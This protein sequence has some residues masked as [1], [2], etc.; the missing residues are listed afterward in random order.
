MNE[1]I[2]AVEKSALAA[3]ITDEVNAQLPQ[4]KDQA[5]RQMAQTAK[6]IK[7]GLAPTTGDGRGQ[8]IASIP[9]IVYIRWQQEYPGCWRDKGFVEEFLFDNPQCQFPGYRPRAKRLHFDMK[10]RNLKIGNPGGDLYHEKKAK[11]ARLI[12]SQPV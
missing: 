8:P 10:H 9:P 1:I 2:Q 4:E 5:A 3:E 11:I 7:A 12:A 6:E